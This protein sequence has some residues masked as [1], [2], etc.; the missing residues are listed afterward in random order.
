MLEYEDGEVTNGSIEFN[1]QPI[2]QLPRQEIVRL[3]I[4]QVPEGRRVFAELTVEEYLRVGGHT[5]AS[6]SLALHEMEKV[7]EYIPRLKER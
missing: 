6:K 7:L 2:H 3:G 4:T 1:D 5:C